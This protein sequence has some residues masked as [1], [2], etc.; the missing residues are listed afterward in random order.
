M[1]SKDQLAET[2]KRL[3]DLYLE[4]DP[5]ARAAVDVIKLSAEAVKESLVT[6]DDND[7]LRKQGAARYLR[8]LYREVTTA[9][10]KIPG[11]E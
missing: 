3:R 11:A 4:G 7:M 10:H 5:I 1:V 9:P 8:S 2:V 6:A